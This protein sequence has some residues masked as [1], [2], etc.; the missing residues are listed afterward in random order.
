MF[1]CIKANRSHLQGIS[2]GTVQDSHLK[3]FQKPENLHILTLAR[4]SL[5]RFQQASQCGEGVR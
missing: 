4:L 1:D 3:A 2:D 5:P